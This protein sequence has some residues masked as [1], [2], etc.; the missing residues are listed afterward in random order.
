MTDVVFRRTEV[1]TGG[2]PGA[3]ALDELQAFLSGELSWSPQRETEERAAVEAEFRRY[4]ASPAQP[5]QQTAP[6]PGA[7][8]ESA[9]AKSA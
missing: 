6:A 9:R 1:G 4:L 8:L 3:A 7:G 5:A 2:H